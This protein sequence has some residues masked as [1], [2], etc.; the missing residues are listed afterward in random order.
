MRRALLVIDVQNE[1]VTGALP[2]SYPP[3]PSSLERISHAIDTAQA[4]GIP[5]VMVAQVAPPTSPIFAEGSD[6]AALHPSVAHRNPDLRLAKSLPSCFSGTGLADWLEDRE[7]DTITVVGFMT[8]NCDESTIRDAAHRGYRVEF[9]SDAS[10]TLALSNA[11][12]TVDAKTLHETV[13]IVLQSRFAAVVTTAQ[14]CRAVAAGTALTGS[15]IYAST[16]GA[17]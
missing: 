15:T 4:A 9:L 6:G 10:G 3:L 2:I 13:S 1:Y 17:R 14:W 11:A 8:Q 12:G 16:A 7:I 5:V